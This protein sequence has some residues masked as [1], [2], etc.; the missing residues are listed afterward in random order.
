MSLLGADEPHPVLL[1]R[2]DARS[3]FI[4]TCDHAG[5]L[6]PRA[7]GDLGLPSHERAR[8]I[9]WDIGALGVAQTLSRRLGC[10]LIAQRYS[11]LV[12][13][14][15][16]PLASVELIAAHSEATTIPGNQGLAPAARAARVDAVYTPYHDALRE[17]LDARAQ[18][19]MPTAY[20]AVHSF[21]PIYLGRPR[22]WQVGVL[23]GADARLAHPVLEFLR[24]SGDFV[25]G[26]NEP[27]RIDDKDEGVPGHALARGLPNVLFE[28]RQDLIVRETQQIAW[29]ERLAAVVVHAARALDLS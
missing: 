23:Y 4:V 12:I 17:L 19:G 7:L 11:R 9:A 22:A 29:G 16:R 26:D 24:A 8:H 21:T 14:C 15:N 18:A 1:E 2:A 3:L 13:D 20:V 6:I 25:V 10:T 27:Y 5:R 28:I